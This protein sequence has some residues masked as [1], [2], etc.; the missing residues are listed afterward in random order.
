MLGGKKVRAI[1]IDYLHDIAKARGLQPNMLYIRYKN[2]MCRT[3]VG[4][5]VIS[6]CQRKSKFVQTL[7]K[8]SL[9][10]QVPKNDLIA[11]DCH[12]FLPY[13]IP[14][15]V[16]IPQCKPMLADIAGFMCVGPAELIISNFSYIYTHIYL[17]EDRK[18][19]ND[20]MQ[21]VEQITHT[22]ISVLRRR[23]IK[24][25]ISLYNLVCNYRYIYIF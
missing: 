7:E 25:N 5:S 1:S 3:V 13:F 6:Y 23:T 21:F 4:M 18:T 15:F 16:K 17:N 22:T 14:L 8:M 9:A 24:V 19:F 10:F 2:Q 11:R 12:H 20:C